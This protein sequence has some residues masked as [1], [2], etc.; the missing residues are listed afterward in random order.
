MQYKVHSQFFC[1]HLHFSKLET[2]TVYKNE[3]SSYCQQVYMAVCIFEFQAWAGELC[4]KVSNF[5]VTNK[6]CFF[7]F[8][9]RRSRFLDNNKTL[10]LCLKE[11][12]VRTSHN[13][14][15]HGAIIFVMCLLPSCASKQLILVGQIM[16]PKQ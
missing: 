10:M 9:I 3:C 7:L 5:Q 2:S 14:N 15:K 13:V 12:L 11:I 4:P 16:Y 8:R 1:K 6:I